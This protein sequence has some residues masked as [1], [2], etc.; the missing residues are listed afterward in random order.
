MVRQ[1]GRYGHVN[2]RLFFVLLASVLVVALLT[3]IAC[4]GD[5]DE[6]GTITPSPTPSEAAGSPT[7]GPTPTATEE[8]FS[9]AREPVEQADP[10]APP[11]ATQT[12]VRYGAHTDYD[13]VVFDFIDNH[14]GYRIEYVEPPILAD[15]SGL[16]VEIAGEAFLQVR[17][18]TAQAHDEAGNS[19]VDEDKFEIMPGLTSVVEIERTG[20]FEGYVTWVLGLPGELDFRVYDLDD[21]IRVVIDVGHP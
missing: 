20:D 14:P 5:D 7:E 2:R 18:S 11:V 10:Q 8:P 17:F 6:N 12:D 16:E 1:K 21:P 19:T 3:G 4:G 13:R 9:G 15:G